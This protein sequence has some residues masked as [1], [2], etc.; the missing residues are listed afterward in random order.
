M[1]DS[2]VTAKQGRVLLITINRPDVRNA[3]DNDV[4]TGLVEAVRQ[5][6]EDP[7]LSAGVLTG[8]GSTFCA[9]MDLK[10]FAKQGV[11]R[12]L[13][14]FYM[15]G[16]KKP[17]IAA[18]EGFALGGGLELALTCD[19]QVAARDAK[20]GTPEVTVGLFAAG[21]GVLRL[22]RRLPYGIAMELAVTGEPITADVAFAHGLLNRITEPGQSIE[23]ALKLAEGIARNAP[24]A[25]NASKE[26]IRDAAHMSDPEF[27]EHQ[28]R[29]AR[30]VLKSNDAKEG[31]RAFAE[32]RAPRWTGT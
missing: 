27:W 21:G 14:T 9:G 1:S 22:A 26:L 6:D 29:Y 30:V 32:K 15:H 8:A 2:L 3:I 18:I 11:P 7:S 4:A 19:L 23:A 16:A 10:A 20:L 28:K 13:H 25:V 5:L 17:L 24:L 31:P 12:D